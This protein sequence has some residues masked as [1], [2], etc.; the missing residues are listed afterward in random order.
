MFESSVLR[1]AMDR[2]GVTGRRS[3]L[4]GITLGAAGLAGLSFTDL[5]AVQADELRKR[6]MACILLW[7]SG[8]PSQLDTWDPKP[9][10]E[11]GGDAR[12]IST[13]VP[14]IQVA[15]HF[16]RTAQ[17]MNE[18]AL[19]RSMTNKEGNHQRATYQLHT[20]Y[21]PSGTVKHPG[22]G[23][24]VGAELGPAKFDLPHIVSIGTRDSGA[25]MGAGILGVKYEPFQVP[26][27][28]KPPLNV[29]L[30]VPPNRFARR[31][32]L[33]HSMEV[34]GF[35]N[36]GGLD[37]V[38][39]HHEIYKQTASMVLSP[40]MQAFDVAGESERTR[41]MY[42][43][44][45]FGQGCLLARRLVEA[46]VTFVEVRSNGW[47]NHSKVTDG[48][49]K[50]AGG[51]DPGFA[52]LLAD[53]KER[54][55]LDRT[56]VIW[57]GEFGRTPKINPNAGR[58][59]F[60]RVFS[61]AMAGAG[62]KGG[63]VIGSSTADGSAVKDQP[64]TVPDLMASFCHSLKIDPTKENVSPQGRPIKIVDGGKLISGLFG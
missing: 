24:V 19:I 21:A 30:A 53:L 28:L 9:G 15:H 17:V 33:M 59:H 51:V 38:R 8:G 11:T 47:D 49:A 64:V 27:P 35:G 12:A 5:M 39:E 54:G 31:L 6:Q 4:R 42:G 41:A 40:Q 26:D 10:A 48:V 36:S 44:T 61:V 45:P 56:L 63:Q 16:P 34:A 50:N 1:V 23:C 7:M 52:S 2:R 20:G 55:M 3:F 37:R 62:V 46:G 58:D 18:V 32:N 57:M 14:G 29:A 43:N 22:F 25:G 60:P 13:A